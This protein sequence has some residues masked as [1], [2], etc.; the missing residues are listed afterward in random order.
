MFYTKNG[1]GHT[2]ISSGPGPPP[3]KSFQREK[4]WLADG[5]W[6]WLAAGCW[7]ISWQILGQ[8]HT[9]AAITK[10]QQI[11]PKTLGLNFCT[12]SKEFGLIVHA[13]TATATRKSE[14]D[15]P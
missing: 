9:T 4:R 11:V 7:V 12:E 10:G 15:P 2:K 5:G 8:I 6:L 13:K 1:D 14:L 3:K